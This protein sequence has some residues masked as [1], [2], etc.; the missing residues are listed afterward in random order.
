V[1]TLIPNENLITSEVTNWSFTDRH[2]RVKIPVQIS[3]ND[4]P[5]KAMDLMMEASTISDR[6]I[7]DPAP[8]V[9]LIAFGESGIDLELRLWIDDP[10]KGV[11]NVKSDINLAI[12][13]SFKDEGVSIPFPQRDVHL[14]NKS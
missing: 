14:I 4:D 7:K 2:V 6:V 8:Q 10:E 11:S 3:Y 1:E 12:W 9:R 5:E 13:K